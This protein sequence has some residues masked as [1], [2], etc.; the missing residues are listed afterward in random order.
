MER[1]SE[2]EAFCKMLNALSDLYGKALGSDAITLYWNALKDV[3]LDRVR[4][5]LTAHIRDPQVGSFMPK[6]ADVIRQLQLN[7]GRRS[8]D[9]AWAAIPRSESESVVW[10]PEERS[11]F[12]D[13]AASLLE[14]GEAIAARLAF[15]EAYE[16][17]LAEARALNAPIGWEFSAGFDAKDRERKLRDA[18]AN[19]R[20]SVKL[21]L[22]YCSTS[23][24]V[25]RL[26]EEEF[27]TIEAPKQSETRNE[28]LLAL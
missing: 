12:F 28:R 8:A 13:G 10:T 5:A 6:P 27:R 7:D 1:Q 11:A 9:E 22:G 21:A 4:Y 25:F 3:A 16:R 14:R 18:I 26:A 23:D 19:G 2:F 20:V 15:K 24:E 17:K